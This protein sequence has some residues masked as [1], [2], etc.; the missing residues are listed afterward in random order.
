LIKKIITLLFICI[1]CNLF[2]QEK[3]YT[4]N[5]N[6]TD[7]INKVSNQR[8]LDLVDML[9]PLLKLD[10]IQQKRIQSLEYDLE[11]NFFFKLNRINYTQ[12]GIL[13]RNY[14]TIKNQ[15]IELFTK[16]L[17]P[18]QLLLFRNIQYKAEQMDHEKLKSFYDKYPSLIKLGE[19]QLGWD[20]LQS[21]IIYTDK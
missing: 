8:A 4:I 2:A 7:K 11:R 5:V 17:T 1:S 21:S 16:I 20:L 14:A 3:T 12:P 9:T 6:S 19:R 15:R 13:F 18:T 10:T